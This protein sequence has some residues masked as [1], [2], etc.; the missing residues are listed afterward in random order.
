MQNNSVPPLSDVASSMQP[1]RAQLLQRYFW[2]LHF[3]AGVLTAPLLLFAALSGLLYVFTPQIE[4]WRHGA[5]DHV[6]SILPALPLDQ[7]IQAA[8]RA[9]PGQSIKTIIPAY[10][11]GDTTQVIFNAPA[12]EHAGHAGH[13]GHAE[14]H[15]ASAI[16]VYVDPGNAQIR[17]VIKEADR[18]RH[19]SRRLHSMMLQNDG[20]RCLIEL[21]ASMLLFLLVSGI[22]LWWP[23]QAADSLLPRGRISWR[24][25]HSTLGLLLSGLT[26]I[27]V[28]TGLTWSQ[29]AGDHFRLLQQSLAQHAPRIPKTL[30]SDFSG[31]SV[32]PQ[33]AQAI[34]DQVRPIAPSIQL[35]ITPPHDVND[36]WRIEN[37]DRS[38]PEKRFQL[39]LDAYSGAVLFQSDWQQL[40]L[41]AK[42]TAVGI[43]FHRGE[44]GGW[45]QALLVVVALAVIFYIISGYAMWLQRRARLRQAG[46]CTALSAPAVQPRHAKAIP[47]WLWL[48]LIGLG[49]ALPMLGAAMLA[50]LVVELWQFARQRSI[51]QS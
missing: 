23:R 49:I 47:W 29:F 28:L 11:P 50:M 39:A 17:G 16:I 51:P 35:Q 30:H 34:L 48:L 19:W 46:K 4:A 37:V 13:I 43:P 44:F 6:P 24:Y 22:Y 12:P 27:I 26:L 7:Q 20:W 32:Q 2:R 18:F 25:L 41:L 21:S 3:F 8:Q 42:A 40:P 5:L 45:N 10:T 14:H 36:I 15:P 31:N 33:T 38:Q 1:S 9:M